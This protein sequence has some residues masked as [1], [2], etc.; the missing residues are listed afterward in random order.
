[1]G[2]RGSLIHLK[3]EVFYLNYQNW[4]RYLGHFFCLSTFPLL[5]ACS[6][7]ST[8]VIF[9]SLTSSLGVNYPL[10]NPLS[11]EVRHLIQIHEVLQQHGTAGA[12]GLAVQF[13]PNRG[14]H[15]RGQDIW[16]LGIKG[17]FIFNS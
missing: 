3:S 13:V 10:W 4:F 5:A 11:V 6:I 17:K 16:V 12:C 14:P 9:L 2:T 1:M 7:S 8:I 15:A